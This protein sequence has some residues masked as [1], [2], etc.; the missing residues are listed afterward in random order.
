MDDGGGALESA[1]RRHDE[2]YD[3]HDE[4][5]A[6]LAAIVDGRRRSIDPDLVD[7]GEGCCGVYAGG[8]G[9]CDGPGG[10]L[11]PSVAGIA[12]GHDEVGITV[13]QGRAISGEG[14]AGGSDR[15]G[16]REHDPLTLATQ[17][18]ASAGDSSGG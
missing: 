1:F 12:R 5:G 10:L 13:G 4:A 11:R 9:Q 2:Q 15:G 14:L 6:N 7:V 8:G 17:A 3:E 18:G 16:G